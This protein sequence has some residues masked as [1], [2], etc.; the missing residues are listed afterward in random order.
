MSLHAQSYKDSTFPLEVKTLP[1]VYQ[2]LQNLT[3]LSSLTS[4]N[5]LLVTHSD[6]P[7]LPTSLYFR[8]L[9]PAVSS[10][11]ALAPNTQS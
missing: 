1:T 11:N 6:P 5:T 3:S 10:W 4:L 2:A 9:A 8:A 7:T